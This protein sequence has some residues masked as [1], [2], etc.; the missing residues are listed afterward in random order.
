VFGALD[1]DGVR[2]TVVS[3]NEWLLPVGVLW[4]SR[5][6]TRCDDR[7]QRVTAL[8]GLFRDI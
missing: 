7:T 8:A 1:A 5:S 6:S 3:G 2:Q 4:D